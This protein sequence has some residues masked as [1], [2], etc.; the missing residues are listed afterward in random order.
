MD[1]FLLFVAIV[2]FCWLVYIRNRS[3]TGKNY[4]RSTH[5]KYQ[6]SSYFSELPFIIVWRLAILVLLVL[7][8]VSAF[9]YFVQD[10]IIYLWRLKKSN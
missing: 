10:R 6:K 3:S 4:K 9:F 2:L 7:S 1:L 5:G 8:V